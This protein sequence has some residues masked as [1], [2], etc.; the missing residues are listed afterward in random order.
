MD[1][2]EAGQHV[3]RGIRNN[4]L[5]ILSHPEF[6][7]TVRDRCEA[8]L[9]SF[10]PDAPPAPKARLAEEQDILRTPMYSIERDRRLCERAHTK[11]S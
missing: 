5:Y 1:P 2:L 3:L 6:E 7:Q 9:A 11:K 8:L 4:H 10:S